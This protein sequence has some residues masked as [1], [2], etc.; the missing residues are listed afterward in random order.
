MTII[1]SRSALVKYLDLLRQRGGT[2]AFV[3]TMGALHR[4]HMALIAEG[5]KTSTFVVCSIFVNPTQFNDP[6][7]FERYPVTLEEDIRQLLLEETDVLFLPSVDEIYPQGIKELETYDLGYLETVLEGSSRPGHFQ[8]V[9]RVMRRLLDVIQPDTLV[10]GQKDY[11]QCMVV[12]RL[13]KLLQMKTSLHLSP[14][15]REEDG[16]AMSSRNLRLDM[17]QRK[18]ATGIYES[19]QYIKTHLAPGDLSPNIRVATDKLVLHHFRVV[20]VQVADAR[21]LELVS[22][23]NGQQ[24]LVALIAAFQGEVR[25]IDNMILSQ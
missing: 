13:L 2:I 12:A 4:G 19:L 11:Q 8:G 25:L 5:R 3:P 7:D 18:D 1:R 21:T 17:A 16:L 10:M 14:T 24:P 15:V 6:R 23:W 22:T 20:Y 9:C